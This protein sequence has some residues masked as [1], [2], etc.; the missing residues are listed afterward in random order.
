M[1]KKNNTTTDFL[2]PTFNQKKWE[3]AQRHRTGMI[4]GALI[5][6]IV[7]ILSTVGIIKWRTNETSF[8]ESD[9]SV[10]T[11]DETEVFNNI[12]FADAFANTTLLL[13]GSEGDYTEIKV[14]TTTTHTV[15]IQDLTRGK[16]RV[17]SAALSPTGG[18]VAYIREETDRRMVEIIDRSLG[19]GERVK[20]VNFWAAAQ[21]QTV[22]PCFWSPIA[23]SPDGE[24]F[25]FFGCNS[26]ISMLVVVTADGEPLVVDES[27]HNSHPGPRQLAWLDERSLIH[28]QYHPDTDTTTA[29]RLFLNA[30]TAPLLIYER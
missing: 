14:A 1:N 9:V 13:V 8:Q 4:I 3:E 17:L 12:Y 7:S 23:W 29:H 26:T 28:T 30:E 21:G 10:V 5:I 27:T 19:R 20:A 16:F 11:K 24:H 25:A 15:Q 18:Y 22:E 6:A 2:D